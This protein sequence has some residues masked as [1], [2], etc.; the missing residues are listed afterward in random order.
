[1]LLARKAFTLG[2]TTQYIIDY[3]EHPCIDETHIPALIPLREGYY[4]T[5]TT[6]VASAVDV[7]VTNVSV[8]E[9]SKVT[10]FLSGGSINEPFTVTVTSTTSNGETIKDTVIFTVVAP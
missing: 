9:G 5:A 6:A 3:A 4:I 2:N 7:T 8:L 10:F 1:M